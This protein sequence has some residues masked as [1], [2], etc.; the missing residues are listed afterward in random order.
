MFSPD[1]NGCK[2]AKIAGC[3]EPDVEQ[4][5]KGLDEVTY[6]KK[7]KFGV[8]YAKAGQKTEEE[9]YNNQ[10]GSASFETFLSILGTKQSLQ[11]FSGFRA[12]L[13]VNNGQT[14]EFCL[15]TK[16][17]DFE[18]TFHVS[19]FLPF[20][21]EDPQQIQ[22]KRH[23]GNDIVCFVYQ[24]SPTIDFDLSSVKSNF[25]HVFVFVQPV[26]VAAVSVVNSSPETAA[27]GYRVTTIYNKAVKPFGPTTPRSTSMLVAA[28]FVR[29]Q[30]TFTDP[31]QLRE[32]LL[33]KAINGEHA[34]YKSEK[35]TRI[36]D[37]TRK[38]LFESI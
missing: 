9:L 36:H 8:L 24:E 13:D 35:F 21:P 2:L 7:Y 28:S 3:T 37:R 12:G 29:E 31:I 10:T 33:C 32:F 38:Q 30:V 22:R 5:I 20:R 18:A 11:G 17:R 34:A 23:I 4:S 6:I 14:G 25:L 1:L 15:H 19:T 26:P 16:W 27:A